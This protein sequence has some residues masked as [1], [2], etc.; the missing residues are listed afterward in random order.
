MLG[1]HVM[2]T[3]RS[4]CLQPEAEGGENCLK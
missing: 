4:S 2:Q 1:L 3:N